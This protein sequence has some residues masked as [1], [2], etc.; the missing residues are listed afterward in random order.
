VK[1]TPDVREHGHVIVGRCGQHS[2]AGAG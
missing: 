2:V 1:A